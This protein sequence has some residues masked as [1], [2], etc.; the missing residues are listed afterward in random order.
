MTWVKVCG[1]RR[2]ADVEVAVEAGA[3]AI[4]FVLAPTSPRFVSESQAAALG[5]GVPVL[6][7]IVTVDLT[8]TELMAAVAATGAGGVQPHGAHQVEAARAA[9]SEGL[10]VLHPIS[11]GDRV[12]VSKVDEG[13]TPLLDTYRPGAH[14]GTGR[15][16]DWAKIPDLARPFVLAGGL[17][18]ANV[19]E[20]I[21]R[22]A[23][24]GVDAS[25]GLESS[26]G[27]KDPD[28]IREYVKRALD[29]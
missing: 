17:G 26:P 4:G 2:A 3:S 19:A 16:F 27:V 8:P 29:R 14:G 10:F 13:Q 20:A 12:E 25:S 11:V 5:L 9:Q 24:W 28:R 22:V 7:V 15:V 1:L 23:P 21:R 6:R 18:P